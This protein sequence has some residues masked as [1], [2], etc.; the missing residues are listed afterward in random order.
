MSDLCLPTAPE[1]RAGAHSTR[2]VAG[3]LKSNPRL[4]LVRE[5]KLLALVSVPKDFRYVVVH[6]LLEGHRGGSRIG[7]AALSVHVRDQARGRHV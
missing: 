2:S 5:S 1:G 4:G 7:R 6:P 3:S